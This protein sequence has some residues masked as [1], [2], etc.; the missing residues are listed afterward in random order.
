VSYIRFFLSAVSPDDVEEVIRLFEADIVP[1]FRD[2]PDCLGIDLVMA[3]E[4][5]VSGL[6]EGGVVTRWTTLDAMETALDS[7]ELV[8]SQERVRGL[9]RREPIR[10][11]YR[12]LG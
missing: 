9:L 2:H 5:G 4:A 1:A 10:K 7:P 11:I 8:E 3:E 6:V 12:V